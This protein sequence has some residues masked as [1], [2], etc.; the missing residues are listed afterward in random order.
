[1]VTS[2]DTVTEEPAL[3]NRMSATPHHDSA[4]LHVSGQALYADDIPLPANTLHAAF[5]LS[6]IAHGRIREMDLAPLQ[7]MPDV[8]ADRKSVV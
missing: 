4:H 8:V 6:G 7:R 1:M 3:R 5:G 2:E